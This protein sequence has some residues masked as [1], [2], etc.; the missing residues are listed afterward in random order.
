MLNFRNKHNMPNHISQFPNLVSKQLSTKDK[1]SGRRRHDPS[2]NPRRHPAGRGAQGK[3]EARRPPAFP[4]AW[5]SIIGAGGLDFR[6]RDGN[7]YCTPAMAAGRCVRQKAARGKGETD[8]NPGERVPLKKNGGSD[9]MAKPPGRLV[10][11]GCARRRACACGLSSPCSAGGLRRD[12][13]P[14]DDC[15]RGG[16][17]A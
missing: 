16:L 17:P 9:N 1:K 13:V 15:P 8:S 3:K 5:G 10:P 6:V 14:R 4:P 7:G 2:P 12:L 11:L